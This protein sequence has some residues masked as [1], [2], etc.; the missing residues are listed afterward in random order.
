MSDPESVLER[1]REAFEEVSNAKP[2][3]E[4][5][6]NAADDASARAFARH[7]NSS[8]RLP[9]SA[10]PAA[11][12]PAH[13]PPLTSLERV[14]APEEVEGAIKRMRRNC[15]PGP[16]GVPS[17]WFK[18]GGEAVVDALTLLLNDVLQRGV[19]PTA[20]GYG[21][22]V[23]L[24]KKGQ[25]ANPSDYRGITLLPLVDKVCRS[26]LRA[27]LDACI[28]THRLLSDFQAG[29][30]AGHSTLDHLLTLNELACAHAE[31]KQ[32]LYMA[33]LDV[34]KAY[35]RTWRD[36]LWHRMRAI[37]VTDRVLRVWKSSYSHVRRAVR[38]NAFDASEGVPRATEWFAC[39]AGVA[40][41]AVDS[42]TLYDVFID[43]IAH[44]LT[45]GGEGGE[46]FGVSYGTSELVPLLMYADD[47]VLLAATPDALQ[48]MLQVVERHARQWQFTYNASKCEVVVAGR[49]QL[50][51]KRNAAL[52]H[53]HKWVLEGHALAVSESYTYLGVEFGVLGAGRWRALLDRMRRTCAFRAR[54]LLW[55]TGNRYGLPTALQL[56]VWCAVCRPLLE[57]GCPLWSPDVSDDQCV[58]LEALQLQFARSAL[59]LPMTTSGVF[60]RGM[61][62]L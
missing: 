5:S 27:R 31:R 8:L 60:I 59:G 43:Q 62:E 40:Q 10:L 38:V 18:D 20:W 34:A 49:K 53:G 21:V 52:D 58:Q 26:V 12:R 29:F 39:D 23:P 55:S 61:N 28:G 16:D 2:R 47:I 51:A 9:F 35:D 17:F 37:G 46:R 19:W 25:R 24:F 13:T 42:P 41:G 57:Y 3:A 33:F 36:G 6:V 45:R 50:K 7:V 44:D 48:R 30:R 54:D 32:P 22:I 15:A 14:V 1:W 4:G 11:D 56:R